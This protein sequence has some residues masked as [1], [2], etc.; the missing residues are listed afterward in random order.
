[1]ERIELEDWKECG[2]EIIDLSY[3]HSSEID[4]YLDKM[5]TDP[6]KEQYDSLAE[7]GFLYPIIARD[8]KGTM[9]GYSLYFVLPSMH[10]RG[11]VFAQNDVYYIAPEYRKQGLGTELLNYSEIVMRTIGVSLID[12]VMKSNHTFHDLAE[13]CGYELMEYKYTKWIG[14]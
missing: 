10:Y 1:M 4:W 7:S 14:G 6:V 9:I 8:E 11:H 5:K 13:H 2:Q 12:V 3:A